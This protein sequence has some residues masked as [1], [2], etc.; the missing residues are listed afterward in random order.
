MGT[1]ITR[2]TYEDLGVP[3]APER[4]AAMKPGDLLVRFA[5]A[6]PR[7]GSEHLFGDEMTLLLRRDGRIYKIAGAEEDNGP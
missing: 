4:P 3:G 2:F 7:V 5:V 6:E 1:R